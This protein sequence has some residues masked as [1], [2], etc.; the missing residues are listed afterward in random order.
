MRAATVTIYTNS[1]ETYSIVA[2]NE[3]DTTDADPTGAEWN[4]VDDTALLPTTVGVGVQ[5]INWLTNSAGGPTKSLLLRPNTEAQVFLNGARTGSRYQLD[6]RA[7]ISRGP[8]SSQSFYIILRG[9]GSDFNGDD[10]LAYRTDRATNSS[11]LFYF[12]AVG[13]GTAAFVPVGTNHLNDAWQHHRIVIDPN[14]LTFSLYLDDMVTPVLTNAELSRCEVAAP[15]LLRI[16]NEGN[17]ADDGY[18]AIDDISLTVEDSRD[19]STTFTDGF[20]SYP[21]RTN[22]ADDA[23]PLGPWITTEVDG[24]GQG[25]LRAPVKVQV[26][27]TDVVTPHS[28]TKCLKI[29]A[30]Q[31]AGAT[32]AWGVPP[33][34]DVQVTWWAR[35]PEA[36]QSAPTADA[37]LLRMSLY[38]AEGGNT[39]S[40]DSALWV[41]AYADKAIR[42]A[43]TG[44]R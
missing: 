3:A 2:T 21:A 43:L 30:G 27:G 11:A 5:V 16:V 10:Y 31:R 26:V 37:V 35:V 8:T 41:M 22:A 14:A 20:E 19:L 40:G 4:I 38:G 23:D 33:L 17:S 39:L 29:E 18:Y 34:S 32:I 12:D 7:Y 9:E 36:I 24:T 13:P 42:I 28:G 6:F 44:L 1:F 25:R 15:T